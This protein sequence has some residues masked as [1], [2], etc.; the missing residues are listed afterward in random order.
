LTRIH[1]NDHPSR[2]LNCQRRFDSVKH[3]AQYRDHAMTV[4]TTQLESHGDTT[5][6]W[7]DRYS[8]EAFTFTL[9]PDGYATITNPTGQTVALC[10]RGTGFLDSQGLCGA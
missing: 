2:Q 5:S 9:R 1:A 7:L 10:P 8:G 4:L 3:S 6:Q